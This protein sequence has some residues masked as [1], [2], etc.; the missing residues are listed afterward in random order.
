M[1]FVYGSG[2]IILL[3]V[4]VFIILK[5]TGTKCAS[6]G[7]RIGETV[8]MN[9]YKDNKEYCITCWKADGGTIS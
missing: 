6:C 7:R 1:E 4:L 9:F 8:P 3:I 5:F 2:G